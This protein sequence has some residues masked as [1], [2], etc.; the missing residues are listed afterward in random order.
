MDIIDN[1]KK[2]GSNWRLTA[3]I[4]W[5]LI[6]VAII[7]YPNPIVSGIGILIFLPFLVFLMFLFF[8]SLFSK[9]DIFEYSPWK[10]ILF[11]LISLPIMLLVSVV[12]VIMFAISIITYFF[13]T[14]W[15]IFY[16]SYLIGKR[17]DEKLVSGGVTKRFIRLLIFFGGLATSLLLL[18]AFFMGPDLFD[19]SIILKT[20]SVDVFP[21]YLSAI[22]LI[23]GGVLIGLAVICIIYMFKKSFNGWFGIFSILVAFYSLFLVLKI[24][25]GVVGTGTDPEELATIWPYLG[26]IIPDLFIIFYSLSTLMGSQAELLNKRIKRFGIDTIIIWL[27]LSKVTYEFIH[28]FPYD[29]LST[30]KI[31][32]IP[33]LNDLAF[34]N[35]ELINTVKNIAVLGFFILILVIIGIYEIHKY[36]RVRK[37]PKEEESDEVKEIISQESSKYEL[38]P[39]IEEDP[40]EGLD[41][42]D[43]K[44]ER[45]NNI[46][47]SLNDV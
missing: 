25:M 23:V 14:S 10:I 11:L 38:Q 22:Y 13:F 4:I 28:Y 37:K 16:G 1:L 7:P 35:E 24:Y 44:E 18:Y 2:I 17:V 45:G 31:P 6:G 9:K 33:W 42:S 30:L 21:W 8:L 34:L 32:W 41:S 29:I 15:F 12:L 40:I 27:I 36:H 43:S 5:L 3:L 46:E 26:I 47:K 39:T 19:F 20:P